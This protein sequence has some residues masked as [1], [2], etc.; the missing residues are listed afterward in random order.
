MLCRSQG[1]NEGSG[2][3]IAQSKTLHS[4]KSSAIGQRGQGRANLSV[5]FTKRNVTMVVI[6]P[7]E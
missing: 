2:R 5:F 7:W 6:L 3:R 4:E 1:A